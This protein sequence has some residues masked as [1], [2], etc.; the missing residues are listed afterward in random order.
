MMENLNPPT[1]NYSELLYPN[2]LT[3]KRIS[4]NLGVY[5]AYTYHDEKQ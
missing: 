2:T 5:D 1:I 4:T 3:Q